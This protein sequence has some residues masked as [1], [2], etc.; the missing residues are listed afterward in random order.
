MRLWGHRERPVGQAASSV[1]VQFEDAAAVMQSE[2]AEAAAGVGGQLA[3]SQH[4]EVRHMAFGLSSP[5]VLMR[6]DTL[7]SVWCAAKP[8]HIISVVHRLFRV[9]AANA[10]LRDLISRARADRLPSDLL[11]LSLDRVVSHEIDLSRPEQFQAMMISPDARSESIYQSL[12][13]PPNSQGRAGGYV[14]YKVVEWVAEDQFGCSPE[15]GLRAWLGTHLR[16][17]DEILT[18][19]END[20]MASIYGR[21]GPYVVSENG[22]QSFAY[23]D[24]NPR[25]AQDDRLVAGGYASMRALAEF[26]GLLRFGGPLGDDFVEWILSRE[27]FGSYD[28]SLRC[29]VTYRCGLINDLPGVAPL[30]SELLVAAGFSGCSVGFVMPELFLAGAF[31]TNGL[32]SS[33]TDIDFFRSRML[34]ALLRPFRA[35][36][37]LP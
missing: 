4:G 3:I 23:H 31:M 27:S 17:S 6:D 7:H 8:I 13:K 22:S 37:P 14:P 18:S 35:P 25:V 26:Y 5:D 11:D 20:E 9:G 32:F 1:E 10:P 15:E 36:R 28:S 33:P 34:N 19:I 21:I 2:L 12:S 30:T 24:R 29:D 16:W